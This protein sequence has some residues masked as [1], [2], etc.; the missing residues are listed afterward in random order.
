MLAVYH[1]NIDIG[2]HAVLCALR[3]WLPRVHSRVL[4]IH[5]IVLIIYYWL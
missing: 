1:P 4:N 3:V 2:A 5:Q